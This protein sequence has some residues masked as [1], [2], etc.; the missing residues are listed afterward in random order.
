[1]FLISL[2]ITLGLFAF[3]AVFAKPYHKN[4]NQDGGRA[5]EM[6]LL[7]GVVNSAARTATF[8]SDILDL[9]PNRG[10]L[11]ALLTITAASGTLPTLDFIIQHSNDPDGPFT[12]L[13]AFTQATAAGSERLLFGPAFRYLR[14][15]S[16]IGGTLPSFTYSL[17]GTA[18]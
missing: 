14:M 10:T 5:F 8:N 16:V 9:G 12:A 11:E 2:M 18:K 13:Q 15:R 17:T 4:F 1:M 7:D 3:G 6:Q